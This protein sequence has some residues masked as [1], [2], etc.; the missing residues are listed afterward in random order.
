M[1]TQNDRE[2]RMKPSH[3]PQA[4]RGLGLGLGLALPIGLGL[5]GWPLTGQ[6]VQV[7]TATTDAEKTAKP[8]KPAK[9]KPVK[10][11]QPTDKAAGESQAERDKRL[12]RECRGKP[13]AAACEG[14]AS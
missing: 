6:A 4:L 14:Y 8:A 1:I 2:T 5:L 3:W 12:L 10:H 7:F 13:N 9:K 11:K